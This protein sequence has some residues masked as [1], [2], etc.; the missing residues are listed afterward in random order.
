MKGALLLLVCTYVDTV[1]SLA[2]AGQILGSVCNGLALMVQVSAKC[3]AYIVLVKC[4]SIFAW[5]AV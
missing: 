4:M 5:P 1:S 2:S 3:R